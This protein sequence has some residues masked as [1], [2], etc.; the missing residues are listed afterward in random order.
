[1]QA[2]GVL[3]AFKYHPDPIST[4][5]VRVDPDTPCLGCNQIR[6]YVYTGPVYT[7]RNFILDQ[8]L[9]PWCIAD[10]SA[11][12]MFGATF[13][14]TGTTEGISDEVRAEVE[15][16]TPGFTAWQQETWLACCGDAA[17]FLGVAGAAELERDFPKAIPAV[18]QYL[19]HEL[20]LPKDEAEEVLDGLT[21]DGEPSAYIFRCLHCHKFLAYVD[22][23]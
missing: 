12:R 19:R 8:H 17:A 2:S 23:T 9:C 3:P 20:E 18:K 4:G 6:G 14:D 13:N 21:K 16:R 11:E 5:S 22:Q 7:E 15:S 10:G 1:M